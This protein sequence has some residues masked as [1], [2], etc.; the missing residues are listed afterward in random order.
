V[1]LP[2][3]IWLKTVEILLSV[4]VAAVLIENVALVRQNRRLHEAIAPQVAAGVQLQAISASTLDG[5][6]ETMA[7]PIT[8]SKLL[9]ITFSPGCPACR[10]N[11]EEWL[12][13]ANT[14]ETGGIRTL[15]ISR[16]SVEVTRDYCL[17]HSVPLQNV[18]A[19]PTHR[20]YLQLGLAR[21]P[22]TILLGTGGQIQRVWAGRLDSAGWNAVR[23]YL[24][25]DPSSKNTNAHL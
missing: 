23:A 4:L 9:I 15:W 24:S 3:I 21:V 7:V 1:I 11:Q 19:D 18:R 22:N 17:K 5:H 12:K 20:T 16:D 6:L 8:S 13:L 14:L 25:V 10:D 2:K